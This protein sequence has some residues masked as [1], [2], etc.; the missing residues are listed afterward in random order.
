MHFQ[1]FSLD[2]KVVL[3]VFVGYNAYT[4]SYSA[5]FACYN[6]YVIPSHAL[7]SE[8]PAISRRF[9]AKKGRAQSVSIP[10]G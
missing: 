2:F 3:T 4:F 1:W 10:G 9:Y 8:I 5:P 7:E 6:A